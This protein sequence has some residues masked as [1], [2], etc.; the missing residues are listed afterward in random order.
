MSARSKWI[1]ADGNSRQAVFLRRSA[2]ELPIDAEYL[3][4]KVVHSARYSPDTLTAYATTITC[5]S[6]FLMI[7]AFGI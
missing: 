2:F 7:G 6:C 4:R 5:D 1:P 3:P